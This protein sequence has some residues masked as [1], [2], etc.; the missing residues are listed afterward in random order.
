MERRKLFPSDD[1]RADFVARVAALAHDGH[2]VV[3]AWA[4]LPNHFHGLV[5]TGERPLCQSMR[6]LLT[7]CVVTFNRRHQRSSHLFQKG[8]G[9]ACAEVARFLR[10]TTSAVNRLALSA[11]LPEFRES[12]SCLH[13]PSPILA[14]RQHGFEP[15]AV[16]RRGMSRS[17]DILISI[18][19]FPAVPS[20]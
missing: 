20:P 6:K 8:M 9:Y 13:P 2:W 15:P 1:G 11:E 18:C 5:R 16:G 19:S 3:Y 14:L 12:S 7:W 10:L 4:L 17:P